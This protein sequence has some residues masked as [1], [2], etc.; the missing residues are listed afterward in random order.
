[1]RIVECIQTQVSPVETAIGR[2]QH[3]IKLLKEYRTR[4]VADVVTGKLDVRT[5][6]VPLPAESEE[7]VY[8][9]DAE[10]GEEPQMDDL[11]K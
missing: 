6:V 5:A 3:E 10:S 7:S 8:S 1:M 11:S 4:L 9:S 2:L